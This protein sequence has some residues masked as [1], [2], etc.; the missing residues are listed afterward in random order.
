MNVESKKIDDDWKKEFRNFMRRENRKSKKELISRYKKYWGYCQLLDSFENDGIRKM[1]DFL[2]KDAAA[3]MAPAVLSFSVCKLTPHAL[4]DKELCTNSLPTL[5][6]M[7]GVVGDSLNAA[8]QHAIRILLDRTSLYMRLAYPNDK[9]GD[10]IG[11]KES[12]GTVMAFIDE[13]LKSN[14]GLTEAEKSFFQYFSSEYAEWIHNF[15]QVDNKVKHNLST[16]NLYDSDIRN[17]GPILFPVARGYYNNEK[18][19]RKK[20]M[21]VDFETKFVTRAYDVFD[22]TLEFTSVV[23]SNR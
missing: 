17:W 12:E 2:E 22:K 18:L 16:Y 3:Y 10:K 9:I 6:D 23:I 13:Q 21:P 11:P 4:R 20:E 5:V 8:I 15:I 19:T 14:T 1:H 7:V